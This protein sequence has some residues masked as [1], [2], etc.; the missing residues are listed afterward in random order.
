ANRFTL[1]GSH[2]SGTYLGGGTWQ[3]EG[4]VTSASGAV[5]QP[6]TI[7]SPNHGLHTGVQVHVVS[8]NANTALHGS[9][10]YVTVLDGNTFTLDRTSADGASGFGGNWFLTDSVL[11]KSAPGAADNS[12]LNSVDRGDASRRPFVLD[13]VDPRRLV[14]GAFGVYEDADT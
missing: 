9:S 12:G 7:T 14:Y 10:F 5:G 8:L 2:G 11:F 4:V 6:V 1:N 13:S 3:R